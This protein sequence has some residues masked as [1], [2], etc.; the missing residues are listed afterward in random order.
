MVNNRCGATCRYVVRTSSKIHQSFGA[1]DFD[2]FYSRIHTYHRPHFTWC[3]TR[4]KGRGVFQR[5]PVGSTVQQFALLE[6]Y[7]LVP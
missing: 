1:V 6:H 5:Y 7:L 2:Y 4:W 3:I